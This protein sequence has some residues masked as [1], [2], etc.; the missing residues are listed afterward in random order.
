MSDNDK[1]NESTVVYGNAVN[2]GGLGNAVYGNVYF[3][4]GNTYNFD[5]GGGKG[6]GNFRK[7]PS[8]DY[9]YDVALSYASEQ[10]SLV[11]R[12]AKLLKFEGLR[13]FYAPFDEGK[14][15]GD[16]MIARFYKI[17]RYESRYVAA[18]VTDDY[19]RKDYTMHEAHSAMFR[20]RDE[21]GCPLIP[22]LFGDASLPEL[23]PDIC[24]IHADELQAVDIADKIRKIVRNRS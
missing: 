11:R 10:E 1:R 6:S 23:D 4:G 15:Q 24:R 20:E 14:F 9:S 5:G 8:S 19:L 18:F 22:I 13:V 3:Q 16:D 21:D 2:V 17:Y 7:N 12:V